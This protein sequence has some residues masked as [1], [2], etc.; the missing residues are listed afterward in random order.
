[1]RRDAIK[2]LIK[3]RRLFVLAGIKSLKPLKNQSNSRS[4]GENGYLCS[5]ERNVPVQLASAVLNHAFDRRQINVIFEVLTISVLLGIKEIKQT[6]ACASRERYMTSP[7]W[8]MLLW[9][10][11][12]ILRR[13]FRFASSLVS[14]ARRFSPGDNCKRPTKKLDSHTCKYSMGVVGVMLA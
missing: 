1:L 12:C 11:D 14:S 3:A 5:Q 8:R 10:R 6:R 13:A 7:I 2:R 9:R 4:P